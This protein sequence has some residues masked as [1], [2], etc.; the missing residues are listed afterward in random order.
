MF[1][2]MRNLHLWI[3]LLTSVLILLEAVT[4]LLLIHPSL[5]GEPE[6][7][8]AIERSARSTNPENLV[9]AA[10]T[11]SRPAVTDNLGA[12]VQGG[13]PAFHETGAAGAEDARSGLVGLIR[14]LHAGRLGS[15]NIRWVIELAA[16]SMIVLTVTGIYL[17]IKILIR[18]NK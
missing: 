5:L 2:K 15:L 16:I 18:S 7:A 4:G 6:R 11:S 17:S 14:G 13:R 9:P 3:G 8:P 10:T 1:K 12:E